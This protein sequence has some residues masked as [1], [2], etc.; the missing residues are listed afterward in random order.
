MRRQASAQ[1]TVQEVSGAKA[2]AREATGRAYACTEHVPQRSPL[3]G[4]VREN[5]GVAHDV[6]SR[7]RHF[8]PN[9]RPFGVQQRLTPSSTKKKGC[10]EPAPLGGVGGEQWRAHSG[11]RSP[12]DG[13]KIGLWGSLNQVTRTHTHTNKR[14][15]QPVKV[16]GAG[17][18][19]IYTVKP[20]SLESLVKGGLLTP[21]GRATG[22]SRAN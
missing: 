9:W 20:C 5:D 17:S 22:P 15:A 11:L 12:P 13:Q 8:A 1:A 7:G 6:V 14:T 16:R 21:R 2:S 3:G 10:P 18:R 19:R 4:L